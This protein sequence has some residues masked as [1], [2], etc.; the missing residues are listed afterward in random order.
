MSA[1]L[2]VLWLGD[3]VQLRLELLLA[4]NEQFRIELRRWEKTGDNT[5]RL[6]RKRGVRVE[7][8][9]L[10]RVLNAFSGGGLR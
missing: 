10:F 2:A 8:S 3:G 6:P 1:T 9:E 5:W 4:H 7:R